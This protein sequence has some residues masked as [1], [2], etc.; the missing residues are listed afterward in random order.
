MKPNRN[1][2]IY[3]VGTSIIVI[4]IITVAGYFLYQNSGDRGKFNAIKTECVDSYNK[5]VADGVRFIAYPCS[6]TAL[7]ATFREYH[8]YDFKD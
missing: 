5:S 2:I 1:K 8:G 4:A 7:K 6:D 3:G